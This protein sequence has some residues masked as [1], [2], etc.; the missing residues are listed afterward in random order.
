VTL[1][2]TNIKLVIKHSSPFSRPLKETAAGEG[3][4]LFGLGATPNLAVF[5]TIMSYFP[6]RF[7]FLV[8]VVE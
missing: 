1:V 2:V 6:D 5:Q 3:G 4:T 8:F 7:K